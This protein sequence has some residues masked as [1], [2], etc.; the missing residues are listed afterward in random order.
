VGHR[1]HLEFL[2][3]L[4]VVLPVLAL[5]V[6]DF[7]VATALG[8]LF[9]LTARAAEDFQGSLLI[10]SASAGITGGSA[11]AKVL[12]ASAA[13]NA[14]KKGSHPRG[15]ETDATVANRKCPYPPPGR[16]GEGALGSERLS[17]APSD[18]LSRA[19]ALLVPERRQPLIV[20]YG[21]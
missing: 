5:G 3:E 9:H 6:I 8:F 18:Q 20:G 16:R 19:G 7:K 11:S 10:F 2:V 12:L 14:I 13:A 21:Q 15:P 17:T 4:D 1:D